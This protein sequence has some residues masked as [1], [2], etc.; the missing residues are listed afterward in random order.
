MIDPYL[1]ALLGLGVAT[2]AVA[3]L[4]PVIEK[5]YISF[6]M[7]CLTFG[8]L[9]GFTPAG[10]TLMA[11]LSDLVL[12]EHLTEI[13]VLISLAGAG[14]GLDRE[15]KWEQW[16]EPARLLLLTLPLTVL[17]VG[18]LG[19]YGA[20]L[21]LGSAI[22]LG[23]V[24]APT[25][26]VLASEVQVKGPGDTHDVRSI[27]TAEA[28]FNDGLA[29][30]FTAAA[31]YASAEYGEAISAWG[32]RW[33]L[34]DVV[35]RLSAGVVSGALCGWV[36]AWL[37]F[38]VLDEEELGHVTTAM[39]VLGLTFLSYAVSEVVYGYGFLGVF[40]AALTFRRYEKHHEHHE[41]S[42]ELATQSEHI[43]MVAFLLLFGLLLH[44]S[45]LEALDWPLALIG[46][47]IVL[48]VRPLS[49]VVSLIGLEMR[50]RDRFAMSFLGIRG[51][52]SVYYLAYAATHAEIADFDVLWTIVSVVIV[53][54][55]FVHGV[56][57]TA[58][59]DDE[60]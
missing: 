12:L 56:T 4:S 29:F 57:A 20:G 18:L 32:G 31:I 28:C 25:D 8:F 40:C 7:I 42:H 59:I 34:Y 16:R 52:G 41:K 21:T 55:V 19:Y 44:S 22:L 51:I 15:L 24:C 58:L 13:A 48:L 54:S 46:V 49:A 17:A 2:T 14:L 26:P 5:F 1:F 30:P 47:A 37:T 38:R 39:I 53:C 36:L 23:A 50:S 45:W 3:L 27:L 9:I 11:S 10:E 35:W 33:L 43:L 60:E 6:P